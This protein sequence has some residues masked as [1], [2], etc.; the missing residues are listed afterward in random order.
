M[1]LQEK[2]KVITKIENGI[3]REKVTLLQELHCYYEGIHITLLGENAMWRMII[4]LWEI[5]CYLWEKKF[6]LRKDHVLRNYHITRRN[7]L[8]SHEKNSSY[9]LKYIT[10]CE[11]NTLCKIDLVITR[12]DRIHNR[13]Y[14]CLE[15]MICS[16]QMLY[17][18]LFTSSSV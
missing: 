17:S 4:L 12:K 6:A 1:F 8:C 16:F 3:I 15:R 5:W 11:K 2:Y 14:I 10:L 13:I 9:S 7:T 18:Y